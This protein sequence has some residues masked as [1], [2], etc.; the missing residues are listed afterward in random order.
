MSE[1]ILNNTDFAALLGKI[2]LCGRENSLSESEHI[3]LKVMES[4]LEQKKYV[5]AFKDLRPDKLGAFIEK[6]IAAAK[7]ACDSDCSPFNFHSEDVE[8]CSDINDCPVLDFKQALAALR[9]PEEQGFT[10]ASGCGVQ[11]K[12]EGHMCL[13]CKTAQAESEEGG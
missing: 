11:V 2:Y 5:N 3:A 9:I 6:A 12:D 8:D 10:C 7:E 4:H 13:E 1:N